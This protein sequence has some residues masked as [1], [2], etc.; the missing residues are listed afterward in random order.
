MH[1]HSK[2]L[3]GSSKVQ[4]DGLRS[5][6]S[7]LTGLGDQIETGAQLLQELASEMDSTRQRTHLDQLSSTTELLANL[8]SEIALMKEALSF[9]MEETIPSSEGSSCSKGADLCRVYQ[10]KLEEL[11]EGAGPSG[12]HR[13]ISSLQQ[14]LRGPQGARG[15][16]LD[17]DIL[18]SQVHVSTICPLTQQQLKSPMKNPRCGHVYSRQA[19]LAHINAKKSGAHCPASGCSAGVTREEL[20]LDREMESRVRRESRARRSGG[21]GGEHVMVYT[22]K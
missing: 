12:T 22:K 7:C 13:Y 10:N 21:R 16:T 6:D 1:S 18:L 4:L 8:D 11:S 17:D 5:L 19:I 2:S 9:L 3:A 14:Y 15:E 20:S